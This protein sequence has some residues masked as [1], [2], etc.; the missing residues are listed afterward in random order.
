M[1]RL[2]FSDK[3]AQIP[4]GAADRDGCGAQDAHAHPGDVPMPR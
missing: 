2:R 4:S 3:A 1:F